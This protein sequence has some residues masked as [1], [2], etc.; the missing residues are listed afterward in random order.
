MGYKPKAGFVT[1]Q[2]GKLIKAQALIVGREEL[3]GSYTGIDFLLP[4]VPWV[5]QA[6]ARAQHNKLDYGFAKV[7]TLTPEDLIVAKIYAFQGNPERH[8]D[9]EDVMS[10]LQSTKPLDKGYIL[11]ACGRLALKPPASAASLLS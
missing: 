10:I 2:F 3:P 8:V 5:D 7:A 4:S 6:V 9:L 1:D 11:Q